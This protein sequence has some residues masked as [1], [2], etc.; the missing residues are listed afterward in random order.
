VNWLQ[1]SASTKPS[2]VDEREGD[3]FAPKMMNLFGLKAQQQALEFIL[4]AKVCFHDE[5]QFIAVIKEA[6]APPFG[7]WRFRGSLDVRPQS[8]IED[9][10]CT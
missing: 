2:E 10:F 3:K 4:P 7:L 5:A 9:A 8:S 1:V 6:L